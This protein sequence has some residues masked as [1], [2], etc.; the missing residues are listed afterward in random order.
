MSKKYDEAIKALEALQ[1]AKD[2]FDAAIAKFK[3]VYEPNAVGLDEWHEFNEN[4][5]LELYDDIEAN[6]G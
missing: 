1:D 5:M 2:A 3:R 6:L 4:V